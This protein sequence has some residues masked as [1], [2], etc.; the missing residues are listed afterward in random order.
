MEISQTKLEN[1]CLSDKTVV[2]IFSDDDTEEQI[3]NALVEKN[4]INDSYLI[5]TEIIKKT[6]DTNGEKTNDMDLET[7]IREN[8]WFKCD[9]CEYKAKSEMS[10]RKHEETQH[11]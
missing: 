9:L 11:D 5:K 6:F 10:L 2:D 3:T 8:S 1:L 7:L 4:I